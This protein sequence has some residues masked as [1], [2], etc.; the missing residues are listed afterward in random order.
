[1]DDYSEKQ[2]I[3]ETTRWGFQFYKRIRLEAYQV[4]V[5]AQQNITEYPGLVAISKESA[6][7]YSKISRKSSTH[8]DWRLMVW[9]SIELALLNLIIN[10][11]VELTAFTDRKFYLKGFIEYN[12]RGYYLTV[13]KAYSGQD[14]LSSCIV[15]AIK[16]VEEKYPRKMDLSLFA[17]QLVD[18]QIGTREYN[19]PERDFL[20]VFLNGY[21]DD[22]PLIC[23][24]YSQFLGECSRF[25]VVFI[26]KQ[27]PELM[28][29]YDDLSKIYT[30]LRE[31]SKYFD[32]YSTKFR[33]LIS[34]EL[35]GR[36]PSD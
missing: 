26:A 31:E 9:E 12:S 36:T 11:F 24:N 2:L 27:K 4:Q 5:T 15:K 18:E 7:K 1:M 35:R 32:E 13:S 8:K 3:D 14:Y 10:G 16:T 21:D 23:Q 25:E 30:T 33:R 17:T 20:A 29:A 19:Y 34:G 28:T 6:V 22:A